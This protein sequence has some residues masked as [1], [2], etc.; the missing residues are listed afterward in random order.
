MKAQKGEGWS[1]LSFLHMSCFSFARRTGH[2]DM[3]AHART[4]PASQPLLNSSLGAA[5]IGV[6]GG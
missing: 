1:N 6:I 2:V 5:F 3:L 4:V